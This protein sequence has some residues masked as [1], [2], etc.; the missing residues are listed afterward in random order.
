MINGSVTWHSIRHCRCAF[1]RSLVNWCYVDCAL[2]VW[3]CLCLS[4]F[5]P[6]AT[7]SESVF[8]KLLVSLLHC[9]DCASRILSGCVFFCTTYAIQWLHWCRYGAQN[10][11]VKKIKYAPLHILIAHHQHAHSHAGDIISTSANRECA[12]CPHPLDTLF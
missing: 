12:E 6:C 10:I 11:T 1:S 2:S 3:H 8:S 4:V 9:S 7:I 5:L